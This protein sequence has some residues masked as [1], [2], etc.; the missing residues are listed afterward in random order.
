MEEAE[1]K[2]NGEMEET[3]REALSS[4][5]AHWQCAVCHNDSLRFH[6]FLDHCAIHRSLGAFATGLLSSRLV[7]VARQFHN[8]I[9]ASLHEG[10]AS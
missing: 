1:G 9:S 10:E 5:R 3:A 8:Q 6:V 4:Q 2:G 7:G